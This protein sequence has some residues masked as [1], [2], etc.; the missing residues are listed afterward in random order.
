MRLIILVALLS[1]NVF[2]RDGMVVT[3][4][5]QQYLYH[6]RQTDEVAAK[7]GAKT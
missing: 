5:G 7:C 1:T 2:A 4:K 3:E 6:V